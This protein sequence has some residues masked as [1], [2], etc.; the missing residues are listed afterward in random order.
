[1]LEITVMTLLAIRTLPD[2]V[3]K[4]KAEPV[5][6]VDEEVRQLMDDM[7]ETMYAGNGI[8]LAANQVGVLKRVIVLDIWQDEESESKALQMANPE[9]IDRSEQ[10]REHEE[11]CLSV[12]GHY[13]K[14]VR[15]DIITVQYL[16]R[17]GEIRTLKADGLLSTCLQHEID[18]LD[19]VVFIDRISS[20][21]RSIIMRKAKKQA[22]A[23]AS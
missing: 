9:I 17:D 12:P 23:D 2:E 14:V 22:R 11:G 8:G 16:D 7:L 5:K 6:S 20:L 3:L 19:G 15:P 10:L 13:A 1:M 21:K 18:H 4:Q